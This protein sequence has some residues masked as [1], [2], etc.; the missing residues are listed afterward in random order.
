VFV[1]SQLDPDLDWSTF[2][3]GDIGLAYTRYAMPWTANLDTRLDARASVRCIRNLATLNAATG[4][5]HW[6]LQFD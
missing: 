6:A 1:S 3:F 4:E 5:L 2:E